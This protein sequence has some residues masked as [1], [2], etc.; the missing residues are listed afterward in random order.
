MGSWWW[1]SVGRLGGFVVVSW[2]GLARWVHGSGLV[3][4]EFVWLGGL[5]RCV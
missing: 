5:D 2:C 3:W 4:V 1:A